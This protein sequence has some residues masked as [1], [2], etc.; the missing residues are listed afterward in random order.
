M[1]TRGEG[2]TLESSVRSEATPRGPA[3]FVKIEKS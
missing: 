1:Q 2:D 3:P